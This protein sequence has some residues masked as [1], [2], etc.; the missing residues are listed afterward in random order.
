MNCGEEIPLEPLTDV[1]GINYV[2]IFNSPDTSFGQPFLGNVL[3][4]ESVMFGA[5]KG[6][7][8]EVKDNAKYKLLSLQAQKDAL[9]SAIDIAGITNNVDPAVVFTV[10]QTYLTI[11]INGITRKNYA[12]SYNSRA[13]YDYSFDIN[14]NAKIGIPGDGNYVNGIKQRDIETARYLIPG[15]QSVDKIEHE[16][17]N[18]NRES[19][20]IIKTVDTRKNDKKDIPTIPPLPFPSDTPTLLESGANI[21]Q[22]VTLII[23]SG[24]DAGVHW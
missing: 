17:N 12:M 6:H 4:L 8:V 9:R 21:Q 10:Y 23:R 16:I 7:F 22:V 14:N 15:V 19:S 3:K 18:W 20:V 2:Q 1:E 24:P 11:Y 13:N 5:G